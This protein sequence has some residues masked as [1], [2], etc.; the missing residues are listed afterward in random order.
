M[1]GKE[2]LVGV[3]GPLGHLGRVG[4]SGGK[5]RQREGGRERAV[6]TTQQVGKVGTRETRPAPHFTRRLTPPH[7]SHLITVVVFSLCRLVLFC[8]RWACFVSRCYLVKTF[9]QA[10]RNFGSQHTRSRHSVGGRKFSVLTFALSLRK[11]T[12][13]SPQNSRLFLNGKLRV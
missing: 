2:G 5:E 4:E 7:L 8:S 12:E 9:Q 11:S 3:V 13:K 10:R 1:R 6:T